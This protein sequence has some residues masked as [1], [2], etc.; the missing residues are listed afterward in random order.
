LRR[1]RVSD[2]AAR[3]RLA[4]FAAA[5][6]LGLAAPAHA[7][8]RVALVIGNGSYAGLKALRNPTNDGADIAAALKGS[9]SRSPVAST[10]T[11]RRCAT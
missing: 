1:P 5:L 4:L 10:S 11:R 6:A 9:T 2:I 3:L 8:R 7:E